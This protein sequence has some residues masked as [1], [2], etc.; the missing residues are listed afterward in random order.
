MRTAGQLKTLGG[1]QPKTFER[2]LQA[3][4]EAVDA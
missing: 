1:M 3:R 2:L 4:K